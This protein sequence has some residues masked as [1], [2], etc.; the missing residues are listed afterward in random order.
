MVRTPILALGLLALTS[1][2]SCTS[3]LKVKKPEL[4]LL[5]WSEYFRDDT[6]AAFEK[7]SGV[8]VVRDSFANNE[9]LLAK[10]KASVEAGG[11]GYDVILPSD[12]MVQSMVK[13]KLLRSVDRP[14][15]KVLE[16]FSG[17]FLKP[18][19]DP[20]LAHAIPFA[21]GTTG[22]AVNTKLAAGLDLAKG[23]SW[24]DLFETK[25]HSGKVTLLDDSKEVLHAAL[26]ALGKDWK[27][28]DEEG[29]K[30]AFAYLK[31]NKRNI[32]LFTA[33]T[34]SVMESDECVLCQAYSGDAL[35][36]SDTKSEIRYM[37]PKEGATLWTDNF[38]FP[39][40]GRGVDAAY[41]FVNYML[42][43]EPAKAF[44][45][46]TRYPTP[47]SRDTALTPSEEEFKKLAFLSEREDLLPLIDRLWTELRS[48]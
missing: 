19:Y 36:V 14:A 9:E 39:A 35:S 45:V 1:L 6:I 15:L 44:T 31:E 46:K 12:Y 8:K 33:E 37:I 23:L 32:R 20:G 34:R 48:Q 38:A 17:D 10:V 22:I 18:A 41:A 3:P 27:S 7:Q 30:A 42:S 2:S 24:K 26:L 28:L 11:R 40:N 4:R 47:V 29:V 21:F 13:L 5:T 16:A 25:D 43:S